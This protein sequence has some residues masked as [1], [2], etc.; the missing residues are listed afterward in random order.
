VGMTVYNDYTPDEQQLLRSALRSAAVAVS[1]ASPGRN[2]ETVSEGFA[3]ADL[4]LKS[5]PGYVGNTLVTSVIVDLQARL[6]T[7]Q[8]FPDFLQIA[9]APGAQA[10]AMIILHRLAELLDA[11]STAEEAAGYKGWLL[12]IARAT[13]QAG[14][15]DQ[16]FLGRGGVLV[17]DA[18]RAAIADIATTL[19]VE[20]PAD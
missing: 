12:A 1:A 16:G 5:Q 6:V 7:Q 9:T 2:E 8:V 11:K 20:Q 10:E 19:G 17:N 14:K 3:A 15:E 18:E 4:I 13:A